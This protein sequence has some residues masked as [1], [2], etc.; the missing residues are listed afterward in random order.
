MSDAVTVMSRDL[1]PWQSQMHALYGEHHG[2]L[3]GWLRRRL[4]STD[5]AADLA[6]D[7][8]MRIIGS[9]DVLLGMREPRAFLT[10][11]AQRLIIDQARRRAIEDAYLR[12]LSLAT[13]HF[14]GA[15]SPE[16]LLQT[17]Q[18][19]TQIE[20]ALEGLSAKARQAFLLHYLDGETQ[21]AIAVQIGVSTRMVHKYLVQALLHCQSRLDG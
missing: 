2:W 8:F 13:E 1:A 19:L 4:G 6:Q 15:P 12:E 14:D 5:N 3:F 16:Q 7:T 21:A 10:T 18:A 20:M 9:R 11:T 17:L